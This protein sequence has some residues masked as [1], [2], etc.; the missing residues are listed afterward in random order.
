M[1]PKYF[2]GVKFYGT[3]DFSFG[4]NLNLAQSKLKKLN[5]NRK[6]NNVNE[7]IELFNIQLI[8]N[9]LKEKDRFH[10]KINNINSIIGR[11]FNQICADNFLIIEKQVCNL[12]YEDFWTLFCKYKIYK[13]VSKDIFNIFLNDESTILSYVMRH[14]EIVEFYDDILGDVLR[15]SIQTPQLLVKKF[16][17]K[18]QENYYLP[19]SLKKE[20]YQ[21]IFEQYIDR[22]DGNTNILLLIFQAQNSKEC[23]LSD[24]LKLRAKRAYEDFWKENRGAEIKQQFNIIFRDQ[25]NI[26][27]MEIEEN[28]I[29]LCYD[30]KW[31]SNNLD[32]STIFNNFIYVFEMFDLNGRSRLVSKESQIDILERI[33]LPKG[34]KFYETGSSFRTLQIISLAQMSMYYEFLE[35]KNIFFEELFKWFFEK[36]L[37]KEF[38]V[39]GFVYNVSSKESN[40]AEKC[41]NLASEMEGVLKQFRMYV[42]KGYIDR[43]LYEISSEHMVFACIP[44][45][46]E[47]KY[48]YIDK[49][50]KDIKKMIFLLFSD[51]AMLSY[52]EK[53]KDTYRT[54]YELL[55][56]EKMKN[57]DFDVRDRQEI[58]WLEKKECLIIEDNQTIKLYIPKVRLLNFLKKNIEAMV[59]LNQLTIDSHLF[60]DPEVKYINFILNKSEYS[61]GLD[62]RNKY[63]HS[64]YS[65]DENVQK[66]DYMRL[67]IIMLIVINKINEEFCILDSEIDK[68]NK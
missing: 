59:Q 26:K 62:L 3:N 47:N 17:E 28:N 55:T 8:I 58:E 14:K 41:R 18:N 34:V 35:S 5:G 43:E 56:N 37:K 12:Y 23:P 44:S 30:I 13:K 64:T 19:A 38:N 46:I 57:E 40:Y 53:T 27:S 63:I 22:G 33:F 52:T 32:Y 16:L 11:F 2:E 60:S 39:D 6:I 66:Q 20:E 9:S 36:Y 29:C 10:E 7:I 21:G 51:Q 42:Q 15:K 65:R 31:L 25:E 49:N 67:L 24:E 50:N 48:G 68:Q 1:R 61:N 54:L 4:E 45:L